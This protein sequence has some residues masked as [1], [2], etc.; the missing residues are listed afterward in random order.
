MTEVLNYANAINGSICARE[1]KGRGFAMKEQIGETSVSRPP[2]VSR[3][4]G[5]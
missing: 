5:P 3:S 2:K 1:T 4:A